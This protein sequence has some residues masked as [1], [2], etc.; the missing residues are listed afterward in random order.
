VPGTQA[1]TLQEIVKERVQQEQDRTTVL[2]SHGANIL[3]LL[4]Y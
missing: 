2:E 1:E 3:P 4:A